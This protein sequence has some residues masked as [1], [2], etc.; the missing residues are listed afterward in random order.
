MELTVPKHTPEELAAGARKAAKKETGGNTNSDIAWLEAVM[1][2]GEIH[3]PDESQRPPGFIY[4]VHY[5]WDGLAEEVNVEFFESFLRPGQRRCNGTAYV[6]DQSGMYIIDQQWERITRP[7]LS[8]P[9]RG[10]VVCHAHGAKIPQVKAAA[11][12]VLAE[13]AEVVALR[14]VGLTG[15]VDEIKQAIDQKVRLAAMNSVL[16]RVGIKG[17]STVEVQLPGYKKVLESMFGDEEES[18]AADS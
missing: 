15:T 4:D 8:Y 10:T 7:C 5:Q 16:D 13:A 17:G 6:R 18:D 2:A 12:R 3:E 1:E 14:L 11:E 9:A